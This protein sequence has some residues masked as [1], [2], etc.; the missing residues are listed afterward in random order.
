MYS[1]LEE[2]EQIQ[3]EVLRVITM[4]RENEFELRAK[5]FDVDASIAEIQDQFAQTVKTFVE[6]DG[7]HDDYLH[8]CAD[9]ADA[10]AEYCKD[11]LA[12]MD[13]IAQ[14]HPSDPMI[15]K[16]QQLR[17]LIAAELPLHNN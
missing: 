17:P 6:V 12:L 5:G 11:L 3:A 10:E 16:W 13:P 2:L 8:A 9:L 7:A 1:H 4:L 15:R 14:E